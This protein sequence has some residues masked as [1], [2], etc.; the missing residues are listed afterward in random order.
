MS[1]SVRAPRYDVETIREQQARVQEALVTAP[2][3]VELEVVE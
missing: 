2:E 1:R 3:L